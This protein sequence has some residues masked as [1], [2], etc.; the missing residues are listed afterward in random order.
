MTME[1]LTF[2]MLSF[3]KVFVLQAGLRDQPPGYTN[4]GFNVSSLIE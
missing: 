1:A 2:A 3:K 4:R